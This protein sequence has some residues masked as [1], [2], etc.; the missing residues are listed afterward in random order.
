MLSHFARAFAPEKQH[1]LAGIP[2]AM[3]SVRNGELESSASPS[4]ALHER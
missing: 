1:L 4:Q 3:Y 2:P